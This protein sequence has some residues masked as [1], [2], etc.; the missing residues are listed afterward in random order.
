MFS[1]VDDCNLSNTE[2]QYEILKDILKRTKS[3]AQ[4]LGDIMRS[5]GGALELS[6]FF[7]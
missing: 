6:K 4:L 7:M 2:Q 1:F 3:D 5:S